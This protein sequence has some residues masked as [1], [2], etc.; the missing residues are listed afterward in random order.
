MKRAIFVLMLT[1]LALLGSG[2][3]AVSALAVAST[4]PTNTATATIHP[5]DFCAGGVPLPC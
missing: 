5:F 1:L 3:P 4:H 2:A